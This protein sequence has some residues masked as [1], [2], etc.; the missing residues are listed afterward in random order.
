MAEDLLIIQGTKKELYTSLIPQITAL[1]DGEPNKIANAANIS[2]VLK[3]AFDWFWVGFYFIDE[4]SLVL[5]PFQGEIACTRIKCGKGVCGTAWEKTE[6]IIVPN[7][8][9][10]PGHIACSAKSKSEIVIPII[11]NN[12]IIGVMDIDS[13]KLDDFDEIDQKY[14]E[15]IAK[16]YSQ[17]L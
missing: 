3:Q 15:E 14:L 11:N 13:D 1:I 10:F 6:T 5:G 16:I 12:E 4:E 17:T 2:A 9:E 8:D 7:V